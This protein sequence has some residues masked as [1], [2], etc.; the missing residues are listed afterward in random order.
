MDFSDSDNQGNSTNEENALIR[1][2]RFW[3]IINQ[4]IVQNQLMKIAHAQKAKKRD[5]HL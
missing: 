2:V 4:I 5:R 3:I 1:K